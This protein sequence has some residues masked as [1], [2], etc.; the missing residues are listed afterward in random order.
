MSYCFDLVL[1]AVIVQFLMWKKILDVIGI[2]MCCSGV[3]LH[4]LE[5]E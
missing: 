2:K 4:I 3:S 1:L 5:V